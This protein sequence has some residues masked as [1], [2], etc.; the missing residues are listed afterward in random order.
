MPENNHHISQYFCD[1]RT[2][3]LPDFPSIQDLNPACSPN[4]IRRMMNTKYG[5][6]SKSYRIEFIFSGPAT[7]FFFGDKKVVVKCCEKDTRDFMN[8]ATMAMLKMFV[9]EDRYRAFKKYYEY[10]GDA[11]Y[12]AAE[13]I[14]LYLLGDKMLGFYINVAIDC[15]E[16]SQKKHLI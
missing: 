4:L 5:V 7:I 8:G 9:T 15:Y 14:L 1:L 16:K 13:G 10:T 6:Q 2:M 12:T 3:D 11:M